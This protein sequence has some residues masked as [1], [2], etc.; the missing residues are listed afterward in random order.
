MSRKTVKEWLK[1]QSTY[2]RYK[3]IVRR[4]DYR[5][6]YVNHLTEQIQMDLVDMGKYKRENGGIYSILTAIEILSRYAFAIP[7]KRKDTRNMLEAVTVLL[8]QFGERFGGYQFDD[9]KGF[10]NV[11]VRT[12]LEKHNVKYFST[13]SDKKAEIVKRFNRTSRRLCGSTSTQRAPVTGKTSWIN[14]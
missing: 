6:I 3:L 11:G 14:W 4:H 5:Q 1:A 2:T 10:Y 9:G 13:N 7:V 12:L 8:K